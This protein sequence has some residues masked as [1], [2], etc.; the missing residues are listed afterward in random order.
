MPQ[1]GASNGAVFAVDNAPEDSKHD[2]MCDQRDDHGSAQNARRPKKGNP[3]VREILNQ[4]RLLELEV[5]Q[6]TALG[7]LFSWMLREMRVAVSYGDT[8]GIGIA[9]ALWN[10][11]RQSSCFALDPARG[12]NRRQDVHRP[13]LGFGRIG[14]LLR[15][16]A[17]QRAFPSQP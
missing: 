2:E 13:L 16:K 8:N 9:A 11:T 1:D 4:P 17:P 14:R 12:E 6:R 15:E 5:A 7:R 10:R 3:V